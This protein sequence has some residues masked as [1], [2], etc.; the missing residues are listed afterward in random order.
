MSKKLISIPVN[1]GI[2][3]EGE[4]RAFVEKCDGIEVF[5]NGERKLEVTLCLPA[6]RVEVVYHQDG[7]EG[8]KSG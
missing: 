7:S 6:G 4:A 5:V 1:R 8:A 2:A 3:D